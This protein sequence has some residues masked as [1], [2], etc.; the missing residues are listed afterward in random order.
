MKLE[1]MP[2]HI[3]NNIEQLLITDRFADAKTLYQQAQDNDQTEAKTT[4][5]QRPSM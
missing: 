2:D 1:A 4:Q 3:R 5:Q